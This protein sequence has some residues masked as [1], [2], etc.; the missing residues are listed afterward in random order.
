[1]NTKPMP[2][3]GFQQLVWDS[4][5]EL[6]GRVLEI[7]PGLGA[8]FGALDPAVEWIGLEPDRKARAVLALDAPRYGHR[9]PPLNGTCEQLPLPDASVDAVLGTYVLCSVDD[10][11]QCAAEIVRVLRP[12]GTALLVDH[13]S[14]PSGTGK[15]WLQHMVTPIVRIVDKNCH[16][17]RHPVAAL[18][19]AGL[20]PQR[21]VEREVTTGI[22]FASVACTLFEGRK[23]P[24]D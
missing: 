19:A 9:E 18:R 22:P 8:N 10:V 7:G 14:A 11:S 21:V 2:F 3:S 24:G 13:V 12:G 23:L 6:R 5:H 20:A 16:W 17:D 4:V 15:A 1:M